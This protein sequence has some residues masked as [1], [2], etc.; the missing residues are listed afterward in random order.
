M[1]SI[2]IRNPAAEQ[3]DKIIFA[4]YCP[5]FDVAISLDKDDE[6]IAITDEC[7]TYIRLE[8]KDIDNLILALQKAK[9]LGWGK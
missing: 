4:S 3:I 1:S 7:G 8:N 9:E 6:Y 5:R 2:D